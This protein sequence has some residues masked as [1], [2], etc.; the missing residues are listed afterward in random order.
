MRAKEKLDAA[1]DGYCAPRNDEG[2]PGRPTSFVRQR[3][4]KSRGKE[5]KVREKNWSSPGGTRELSLLGTG[6]AVSRPIWPGEGIRHRKKT[7]GIGK[8]QENRT[9]PPRKIS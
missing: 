3:W 7:V 8:I 9:Y 5:E 6:H 2:L 1:G 4:K